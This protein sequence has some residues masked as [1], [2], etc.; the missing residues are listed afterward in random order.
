MSKATSNLNVKPLI[1]KALSVL[2]NRNSVILSQ[3]HGIGT[4]GDKKTLESIG[5]DYN[6]TRER[7][8]QIEEASY[9]KIRSSDAYD[10]LQPA[11]EEVEEFLNSNCG[12]VPE[13]HLV[14]FLVA[15]AQKPYLALL[16]ALNDDFVKIKESDNYRA[17][18][19]VDGDSANSV[20][21]F[22]NDLV[23]AV[24]NN[25]TTLSTEEL[26]GLADEVNQRYNLPTNENNITTL[27]T[28][29]KKLQ[30]GPFDK[31]GISEWSEI[32]PRGVRDKV[33]L[34]LDRHGEPLHFRDLAELIDNSPFEDKKAIKKT[35]PQTVHNELIK[36]N[37]FV[38]IGRGIY[39]LADW[40]Y[41]PGT[42]KDVIMD[43]LQKEGKP[44]DRE[45]LISRVMGQRKVQK[46]TVLLNLQ[47]KDYFQKVEE[48]KYFLA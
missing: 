36:D 32:S 14:D 41:V 6:I 25:E 22:L 33:Y 18:W 45:S 30:S 3:R 16:L 4:G 24:G 1:E 9:S 8:R 28:I 11:F 10:S 34:V 35:H 38:L 44:I 43:I 39:A 26:F 23:E 13:T 47:N 15:D 21:N 17:S 19:A 37:R 7:V 27:L 20:R 12:A 40:G 31:W 2:S 5:S 48:N 42:V 29:S 46:N